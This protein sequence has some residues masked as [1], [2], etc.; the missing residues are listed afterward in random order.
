MKPDLALRRLVAP[1]ALLAAAGA[2]AQLID[3]VEFRRDGADAILQVRFVTPVVFRRALLAQSGDSV[4][5]LYDLVDPREAQKVVPSE[6]RVKG[7]GD[8][9][10]FIVSDEN[11]SR[12]GP[13]RRLAVR[14]SQPAQM[15]A[16]AGSGPSTAD[17]SGLCHSLRASMVWNTRGKPSVSE[18]SR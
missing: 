13:G 15:R 3:D 12:A 18:M 9:P 7:G 10:D 4:Q 8:M 16:R 17:S 2:H 11:P 5:I 14:L 1:I 6:R